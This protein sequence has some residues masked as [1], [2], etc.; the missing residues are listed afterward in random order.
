M[1]AN[2]NETGPENAKGETGL[3][4]TLEQRPLAPPADSGPF[5]GLTQTPGWS[6]SRREW[7]KLM[8]A[9]FALAG[10]AGCDGISEEEIVPYVRPPQHGT[11]G[12]PRFY[13]TATLLNGY[14]RGVIA[15]SY[16]GR[17]VKLEG[18]P[19]HPASLGAT[20]VFGQAAVLEL[21][22]PE[23]SGLIRERGV[24]RT[25]ETWLKAVQQRLPAWKEGRGGAVRVLTETLTSP[26]LAAQLETLRQRYPKFRWHQYQP[27]NDD[28]AQA[29]SRLAFGTTVEPRWRFDVADVVVALDCDFLGS[30]AGAD[31]VVWSRAF[32]QRRRSG[33]DRRDMSRLYVLETSPTL[34][35]A[36]ADHRLPLSPQAIQ[37]WL[38]GLAKALGAELGAPALSSRDQRRVEAIARDL[39]SRRGRSLLVAGRS[40]PPAV[41][42]LVHWL[43][44]RLGSVGQTLTYQAPAQARVEDQ[45]ESL[46]QLVRDMRAGAVD[47]LLI[48]GGNPVYAA[49]A[50][51]GFAGALDRVPFSTHVSLYDDETS[52]RA[53]WH[54]P[55]AHDLERW[56]DARA[57][58]GSACLLQPLIAPLQGGHSPHSILALLAGEPA[59]DPHAMLRDHWRKRLSESDFEK[60][61]EQALRQG[62]IA[63]T[64]APQETPSLRS[65]LISQLPDL[66][67]PSQALV[68]AFAPDS[69]VWDGRF[70]NNAWLQELPKPLTQLTWDNALQISPALADRT[71]LSNGDRVEIRARERTLTAAVWVAPGQSETV[72]ALSLGY[73]RE[74]AGEV[75]N[76]RGFNAYRLRSSHSPWYTGPVEL[77]Q[78]GG[79]YPLATTQMHHDMEGRAPVRR[80]TLAEYRSQPDF[81]S[82]GEKP[83][84]SLY[85]PYEYPGHAW[86][87]FVN[88]NTCIGCGACT[89]A[90]QAEN[91]IPVV[92]KQEVIRGREM[93][94]IRVDRYHE[95]PAESPRTFFQPVPCMH[96]EHAPCELVCP[97]GATMHDAEGLNV[98]VYNRCIG[99]RFCSNNCPYKV[100][101]FN[102]LAYAAE[103]STPVAQRNPEVTVRRRGVMEKCTYCIQRIERTRIRA[104]RQDRA[105]RDDE[106]VTACQ[107]VC[108]TEAIVFGDVSDARSRVSQAKA[109][110]LNYSL[111]AELNT[112]PRT[113]YGA[114]L[115]NPNPAMSPEDEA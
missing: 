81:A 112:R 5:P 4:R 95:G 87:M 26:T 100:R 96:C 66:P 46:R 6:L 57:P 60:R 17:P 31:Q 32:M 12:E 79:R 90:C 93:H 40:Q 61:W 80:A 106:V 30:G 83:H 64:A 38:Y 67:Q 55:L 41:H 10:L 48:L 45:T 2:R 105:I 89:I 92:G 49:P 51:L 15:T 11:Q 39:E 59:P 113:T 77:Q 74:R 78:V 33:E 62:V 14:A 43:N 21:W 50:D 58:D 107:Q 13:A 72:V 7:M 69:S 76:G 52:A 44:E 99:T 108:P 1:T 18:N 37:A 111:L 63:D 110:P 104:E 102:F 109:T 19:R 27:V 86:G 29:G 53:R 34:T 28:Q 22:D 115:R 65:E 25:L 36:A 9:S 94:W 82:A 23:R 8:G 101:R 75:G 35:G 70:A 97:V 54:L 16:M 88:L 71:G 20:D 73:G 98:Q 3:W 84:S 85:P 47:T 68:L 114:R 91:N 42:A 56:G 103:G 24:T